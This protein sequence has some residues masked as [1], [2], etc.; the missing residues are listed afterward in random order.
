MQIGKASAYG[1]FA[2]LY[3]ASHEKERPSQGREIVRECGLPAEYL[4]KLL[5]QLSRF[6]ILN[7][8]RGRGGGFTLV[9]PPAQTSLLEIVEA[10]EG[11]ADS[12]LRFQNKAKSSQRAWKKFE[13]I[14]KDIVDHSRS[15]LSKATIKQLMD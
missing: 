2:T 11:Q 3:V 4:L 13:A 10:I 8:T 5:G 14:R 6:R 9:K 1:I 12:S 15:I 7:G